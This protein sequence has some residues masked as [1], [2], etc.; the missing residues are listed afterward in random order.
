MDFPIKVTPVDYEPLSVD[1]PEDL[2]KVIS[3]LS[4]QSAETLVPR[5]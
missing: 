3:Y 5:I 2:R 1:T 4:R